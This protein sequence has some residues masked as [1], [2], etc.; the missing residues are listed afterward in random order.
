[1]KEEDVD[2]AVAHFIT[3][4]FQLGDF[5]EAMKEDKLTYEIEEMDNA[6]NKKFIKDYK[7]KTK[8]IE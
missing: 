3:R 4:E 1:M 6:F 2:A 7:S 5:V 8:Q